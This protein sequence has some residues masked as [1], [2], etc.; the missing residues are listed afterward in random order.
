M[1]RRALLLHGFALTP[2]ASLL[3]TACGEDKD[4]PNGMAVFKWDRDVCTR[5][6][7]VISDH[8]FACQ[9][10]GGPKDTVFKFDDIGCAATWL[11]EKGK[12]FPWMA[13]TATRVWVAQFTGAGKT[14][15]DATAAYY[16][17]GK[18]SPMGYNFAAYAEKQADGLSFDAMGQKTSS[19]WP[20]NCH[21]G[22]ATTASAASALSK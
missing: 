4:L 13:D 11:A 3:L 10:R 7:M 12:E 17:F 20:A 19:T 6:K 2:L 9:I 21:P 22:S 1:R 14:W 5:C 8:R 15:L 16:V 18:T